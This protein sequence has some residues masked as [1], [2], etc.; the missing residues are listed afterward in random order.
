MTA[1]IPHKDTLFLLSQM[2]KNIIQTHNNK[3]PENFLF[4]Q[5]PMFAFY[6]E[7]KNAECTEIAKYKKIESASILLPKAE[8]CEIYF[9]FVL[10]YTDGTQDNMKIIFATTKQPIKKAPEINSDAF[11]LQLRIFRKARAVIEYNS[12]QIFDDKWVKL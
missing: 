5:Y 11:P 9:P 8:N 1:Y 10:K 4:P 2:Q 6:D 7:K 12:W 3:H